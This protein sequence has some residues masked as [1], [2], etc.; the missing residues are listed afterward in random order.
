MAL[1]D[2]MKRI[3]TMLGV[4]GSTLQSVRDT[5]KAEGVS[6]YDIYLSVKGA[7]ITY[8]HVADAMH[9][10]IPDTQPSPIHD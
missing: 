9:E 5:L 7:A 4:S 10:A 6:E 3:S 1:P 2:L 8:P